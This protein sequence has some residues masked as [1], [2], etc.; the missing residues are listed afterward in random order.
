MLGFVIFQLSEHP[1]S[2]IYSV[3]TIKD[4][5]STDSGVSDISDWN[6]RTKFNMGR[7]W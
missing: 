5:D 1:K 7:L 4:P 3:T 6:M 2:N